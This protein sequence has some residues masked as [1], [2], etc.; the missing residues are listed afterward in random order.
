MATASS[1]AKAAEK[2]AASSAEKAEQARE[3]QIKQAQTDREKEFKAA[4]KE[5]DADDKVHTPEGAIRQPVTPTQPYT[6]VDPTGTERIVSPAPQTWSPAE[7]E[8]DPAQVKLA[9]ERVLAE[10]K[11]KEL[12]GK[13][14]G[15]RS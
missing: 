5:H 1:A 7:V 14:V 3:D 12:R 4:E 8:P 10:A 9:E 13:P 11:A 2:E 15:E 6:T